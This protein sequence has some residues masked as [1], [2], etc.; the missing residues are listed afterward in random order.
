MNGEISPMKAALK[1]PDPQVR[2][3][4]IASVAAVYAETQ[5]M[6]QTAARFGAGV[7]TL[8]RCMHMDPDLAAAIQK[9]RDGLNAVPEGRTD[10]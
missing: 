9:I 7:R 2:A 6:A 8:E 4:Y 3:A 10:T 5:N 1:H